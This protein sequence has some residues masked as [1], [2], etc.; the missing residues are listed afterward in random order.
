MLNIVVGEVGEIGDVFTLHTVPKFI[1][2][3][4]STRVGRRIGELAVK[5]ATL[6]RVAL[7]LGGKS[8]NV[9]PDD[10]DFAALCSM[11]PIWIGR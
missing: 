2:F 9:L 8:P 10:A 4:G 7:E 6:K 11:T 5:G 3:T 1:S